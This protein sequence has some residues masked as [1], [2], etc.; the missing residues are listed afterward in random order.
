MEDK[1]KEYD[2]KVRYSDSP[3]AKPIDLEIYDG[4]GN[5]A[6]IWGNTPEDVEVECDHP[7]Q[8]VDFDGDEPCGWCELCGATCS[9]HY[10]AEYG[11]VEGHYWEGRRLV[12]TDWTTPDKPGGLIGEYLKELRQEESK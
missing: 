10:E 7:S 12:P 4:E 2:L 3:D 1:L 5:V 8:C 9:T 6:W 11:N